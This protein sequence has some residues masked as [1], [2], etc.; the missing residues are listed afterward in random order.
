MSFNI[1]SAKN[2]LISSLAAATFTLSLSAQATWELNTEHSKID[3]ISTKVFKQ[4]AGSKSEHNHFT[5]LSGTIGAKGKAKINIDLASVETN[6]GIRN[7]RLKT[8]IF[9]VDKNPTATI[10]TN[11]PTDALSNGTHTLMLPST[12]TLHG[13]SKEITLHLKANVTDKNI[14]VVSTQPVFVKAMDYSLKEGIG[15]LVSLM[16]LDYIVP[17]VPVSFSVTFDKGA[18]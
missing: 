16:A 18:S 12:L 10:T 15:K 3:F 14:S 9:A 13:I 11:I 7:D 17:D 6:V 5:K 4:A 1:L 8:I 2:I